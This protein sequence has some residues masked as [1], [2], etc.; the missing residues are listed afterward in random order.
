MISFLKLYLMKIILNLYLFVT[1]T[2]YFLLYFIYD[3][4]CT[5]MLQVFFYW[6]YRFFCGEMFNYL[7]QRTIQVCYLHQKTATKSLSCKILSSCLAVTSSITGSACFADSPAF[8]ATV[9][10]T[11]SR[12]TRR[13]IRRRDHLISPRAPPLLH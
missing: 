8:L 10:F 7:L 3:L 11:A 4:I 1:S 5:R 12:P 6:N 2:L 9:K 13:H